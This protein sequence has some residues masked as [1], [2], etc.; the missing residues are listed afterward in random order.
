MPAIA[1]DIRQPEAVAHELGEANERLAHESEVPPSIIELIGD[2]SDVIGEADNA[3]VSMIDPS[4]WIQIQAAAL[5]AQRAAVA[6]D[7]RERRRAVRIALEQIRFLFARLSERQPVTEDRP[8]KEVLAWLDEKLNVPQ[9]RK[10]DLLG[11]GERTYQRWISTAETAAPEAA[12]EHRVRVV[13][14][15]TAQLRHVLTGAG[16]ADWFETPLE[17]LDDRKPLD[18]LGDPAATEQVLH[19]AVAPRSFSAA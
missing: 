4:L 14:R 18:V 6:N 15:V 9:R 19:L 7:D 10:A 16:V 12:Q 8:I 11:V 17:D 2:L 3:T 1:F 5:R 13:A